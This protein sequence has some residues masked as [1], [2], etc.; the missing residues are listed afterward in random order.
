MRVFYDFEFI[1]DG[2]IIDPI[3]VGM[4]REDGATYYAEFI[5][6][7]L[8]PSQWVQENVMPLLEGGETRKSHLTIGNDII[9]FVGI[10]PQFWGYYSAYD[11][12]CLCQLFGK[13]IDLPKGFPYLTFDVKQ[14]ASS[15]GNP[16]LPPRVPGLPEHHGLNDALW[17]KDAWE[18]LRT[19]ANRS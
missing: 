11:H 2:R 19:V 6:G 8:E 17:I 3:S 4:V 12:V 7:E 13:M 14:L 9:A 5:G 18:F 15:L 10:E 16:I 1:E